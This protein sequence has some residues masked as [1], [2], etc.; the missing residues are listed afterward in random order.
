MPYPIFPLSELAEIS[1]GIALSRYQ[2][3]K[4]E[5][6]RIV[7]LRNLEQLYVESSLSLAQLNLPNRER[8][9]LFINDI[10]IS[11]RGIPL[12][13]SVVTE[14]VQGSLAGQNLA[15]L[16]PRLVRSRL[17][18]DSMYLAGLMRSKW[19]ERSL[20]GLY[21]QSTGTQLLRIAQLRNIQV[22]LPDLVMQDKLAKLFLSTEYVTQTTL[23]ALEARQR[24]TESVFL[25]TIRTR[26]AHSS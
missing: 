14:Q 9:Q 7:N 4:G 2:D 25:Q 12:K 13:A 3:D 23:K 19:F 15:V 21:G 10:V 17:K 18:V 5:K 24:L 11:I 20:A 8:H 16:R 22:P 6:E 26:N 1:Q